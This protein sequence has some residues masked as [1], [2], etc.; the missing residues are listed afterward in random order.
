LKEIKLSILYDE[1]HKDASFDGYYS[2]LSR[3]LGGKGERV[4]IL[5]NP[6]ITK[7]SLKNYEVFVISFPQESFQ[8]KEINAIVE[9]VEKGG[10]L[11]LIGEEWNFNY[12]KNNLNAISTRF[13]VKFNDDEVLDPK[14][15]VLD[16]ND[17]FGDNYFAIRE[18]SDHQITRGLNE[19]IF[20][21]GCSLKLN[22]TSTV[23][24]KGGEYS[25]SSEGY[26]K[27]GEFPPIV[28]IVNHGK[29]KVVCL[30]DGSILRDTFINE[31]NN[32]QLILNIIDWLSN[33]NG[34]EAESEE[35][36]LVRI[37]EL[38]QKYN[39][40]DLMY[41]N[42]AITPEEYQKKVEEFAKELVRLESKIG[43]DV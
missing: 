22:G 21:G 18:L 35:Q 19:V 27:P 42:K 15:I 2:D 26:Y 43:L 7:S 32:K 29:G 17:R 37:E 36:I 4:D 31:G 41:E 24:V 11:F 16:S 6:P 14:N 38:E 8:V 9:F 33:I 23:L 20:Y 34:E 28:A 13:K 12:F 40:L 10:G 30:G 39:E 25:Y 3:F 1:S 5:R